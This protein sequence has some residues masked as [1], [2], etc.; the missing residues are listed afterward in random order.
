MTGAG[1]DLSVT[2]PSKGRLQRSRTRDS[3]HP[4]G[5]THTFTNDGR[6]SPPFTVSGPFMS[7]TRSLN[8]NNRLA[9]TLGA[10]NVGFAVL[11]SSKGTLLPRIC[12]HSYCKGSPSGSALR[13]PF[14]TTVVPALT[15]RSEPA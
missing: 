3:G 4:Q 10:T 13:R 7:V 6:L 8:F 2:F 1:Q 9:E 11:G 12:A 14:S 5:S 15:V